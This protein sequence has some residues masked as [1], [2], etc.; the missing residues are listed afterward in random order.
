MG[1]PLIPH[2]IRPA[3][4]LERI[5][6]ADVMMIEKVEIL[7]NNSTLIII[8]WLSNKHILMVN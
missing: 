3:V 6:K 5:A 7:Y 2:V 4:V 8:C 1:R